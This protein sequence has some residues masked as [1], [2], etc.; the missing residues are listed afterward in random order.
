M[1]VQKYNQPTDGRAAAGGGTRP[2]SAQPIVLHDIF[3]AP[4]VKRGKLEGTVN[5]CLW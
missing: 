5:M 1:Y 4:M 3:S 2:R